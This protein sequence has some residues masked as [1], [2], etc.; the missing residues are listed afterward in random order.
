MKKLLF[1]FISISFLIACSSSSKKLESGN[2]DAALKKSAKKIRKSPGKFEEV[3]TFNAAYKGAYNKDNAELNRLKQQGNPA[4]WSKIYKIYVRMKGRQ[5]L[6]A[7]LPPVGLEY[8]ERDYDSEILTA[9]NN[10]TEYA[11]A[12][13]DE[14]MAKNDRM[15]ARKAYNFYKEAKNYINDF[16]DVDQKI[17][18][19]KKAG[20]T[21]VFFR[22]EDNAEML[23]PQEMMQEIQSIDV[24]DLDKG[25]VNY[26]SYIDTTTLYHYSV[27]LSVKLI[28]VTPDDLAKTHM[29]EKKEVPDGFDYVLDGNGNV[30]KDSLGN[31]IK[32]PKFKT[33]QCNVTR[34]HQTKSAR[35]SGDIEYYDN[36]TDQLLKKEPIVSESFFENR[37]VLPLG[38]IEA[39]SPQTQQELN[40]KPMPY[41]YPD[42]LILQA[43]DVMKAMSKEIL[44]NNKEFLK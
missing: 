13:G 40:T 8:Q 29:V 21:N 36:A 30:K 24:N 14:L 37:Y 5:D 23:V 1:L 28:E 26:D 38:N 31:D 32:I 12:K 41:P 43:G 11:Y 22:I 9:K 15:E 18:L 4:N 42:A 34:Y 27:I 35:I 44:V 39:L 6:A 33:I 17:E 10:A 16:K 25:W 2:Y 7:S 3:N 20:I 19:A